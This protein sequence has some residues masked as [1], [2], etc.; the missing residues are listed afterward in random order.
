MHALAQLIKS[1]I[2]TSSVGPKTQELL[3]GL[4]SA[5]RLRNKMDHLKDNLGNLAAQNGPSSPLFG[6]LSYVFV[7]DTKTMSACSIALHS[8]ALIND[9]VVPIVNPIDRQILLPAG[10]FQLTAFGTTLEFEPLMLLLSEHFA[11]QETHIEQQVREAASAFAI[12]HGVDLEE[13]MAS[14]CGGFGIA[15]FMGLDGAE[16]GS[17]EQS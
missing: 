4:A 9:Q 13:L 11:R 7:I 1:E 8:G 16:S 5:T 2:G 17:D 12:E 15:M 14:A 6:S 3:D 10:L